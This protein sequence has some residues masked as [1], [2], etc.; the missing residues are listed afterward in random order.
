MSSTVERS[1]PLKLE[2]TVVVSWKAAIAYAV[3]TVLS[4]VLLFGIPRT[5]EVTYKL[6]PNDDAFQ[7]AP[8]VVS[9]AVVS[10]VVVA[11]LAV[12]T[13]ASVMLTR[14]KRKTPMCGQHLPD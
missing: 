14:A 4:A 12:A 2:T 9:A 7:L 13:V 3:F 8:L 1:E 5:G 10:V 11:L 6:T